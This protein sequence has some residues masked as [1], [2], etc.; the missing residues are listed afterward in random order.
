MPVTPT[1]SQ[2]HSPW[3][4][5]VNNASLPS[6]QHIQNTRCSFPTVEQPTQEAHND[7]FVSTSVGP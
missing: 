7:D 3:S 4:A 6:R 2:Y 5:T 1:L